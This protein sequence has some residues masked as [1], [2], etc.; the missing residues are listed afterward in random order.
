MSSAT[1]GELSVINGAKSV[2]PE[3]S[4]DL[5]EWGMGKLWSGQRA[6]VKGRSQ[7][8]KVQGKGQG[9]RVEGKVEGQ[10]LAKNA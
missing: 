7:R 2:S 5:K 1:A 4:R 6:K 8:A 10:R 3:R 9:Q